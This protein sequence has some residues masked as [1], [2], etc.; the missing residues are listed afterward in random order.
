M[1]Q[2]PLPELPPGAGA[3]VPLPSELGQWDAEFRRSGRVVI[4][5][6]R[7]LRYIAVGLGV[8]V[9]VLCAATA[10]AMPLAFGLSAL[11]F[12]SI[13]LML[14]LALAVVLIVQNSR[15]IGRDLIVTSGGVE[16]RGV[17]AVPWHE[18]AGVR[19]RAGA[20]QIDVRR[21]GTAQT[22]KAGTLEAP[23]ALVA[24][25]LQMVRQRMPGG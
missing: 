15:H 3:Q 22:L 23:A 13:P 17:G 16:V 5:S 25:W 12:A 8:F 14:P 24:V 1:T 9:V 18:V 7:H 11:V 6:A 19:A 10:I 20:V 4:R 2:P 21:G